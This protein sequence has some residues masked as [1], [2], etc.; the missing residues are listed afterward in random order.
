MVTESYL[1]STHI[2]S[3]IEF[4]AKEILILKAGKLLHKR[5]PQE[6]LEEIAGKGLACNS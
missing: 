3:D 4:I 2:V 5:D 1:L 6:L